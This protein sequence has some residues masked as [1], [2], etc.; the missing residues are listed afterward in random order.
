MNLPHNSSAESLRIRRGVNGLLNICAVIF[1]GWHLAQFVTLLR[2]IRDR[3]QDHKV[4]IELDITE[5]RIED[6]TKPTEEEP[7]PK[8]WRGT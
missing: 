8:F 4:I 7:K 2:E 1:V 6:A 3:I 5:K